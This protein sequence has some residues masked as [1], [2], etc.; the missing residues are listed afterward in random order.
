MMQRTILVTL[1][2]I[3]FASTLVI[4]TPLKPAKSSRALLST[5][6]KCE[7]TK[8]KELGRRFPSIIPG[9]ATHCFSF[10]S[11]DMLSFGTAQMMMSTHSAVELLVSLGGET[12]TTATLNK[13]DQNLQE[14][15]ASVPPGSINAANNRTLMVAVRNVDKVAVPFS[16]VVLLPLPPCVYEKIDYFNKEA[17]VR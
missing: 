2:V 5:E 7:N 3:V 16:L 4:A 1:L 9:K 8:A 12:W 15:Q 6:V 11:E 17:S 10:N 14:L 13:A